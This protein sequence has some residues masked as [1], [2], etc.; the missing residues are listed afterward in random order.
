MVRGKRR[1][2]DESGAALVEFAVVIPLLLLLVMGIIDF[3]WLLANS[4]DIRHGAREAARQA[5]VNAGSVAAMG[6]DACDAMDL[7]NGTITIDFAQSDNTGNAATNEVGDTGSV[8]V[9]LT[10]DSLTNFLDPLLPPTISTTAEVRLEQPATW[11][12]GSHSC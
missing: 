12:A 2:Q 4:N 10:F 11:S 3:G 8:T 9:T 7:A 6:A 5:A 1:S